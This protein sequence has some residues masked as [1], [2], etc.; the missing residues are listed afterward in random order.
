MLAKLL[1]LPK[2]EFCDLSR[3]RAA[4]KIFSL[5]YHHDDHVRNPQIYKRNF[6]SLASQK[7]RTILSH[8]VFTA[9]EQMN[10]AKEITNSVAN[11]LI[12][13]FDPTKAPQNNSQH[14]EKFQN[15]SFKL[16]KS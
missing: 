5:I 13:M 1:K 8:K 7:P 14:S 4:E 3:F 9:L 16:N 6:D 10:Q 15:T 12:R 11:E 2:F